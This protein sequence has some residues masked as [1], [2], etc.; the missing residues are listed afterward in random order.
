MKNKA[1]AAIPASRNCCGTVLTAFL[2]AC[3][4][5]AETLP[6]VVISRQFDPP[7]GPN[8]SR[9]EIHGGPSVVYQGKRYIY[10]W[11]PFPLAVDIDANGTADVMI[12][13]L[14]TEMTIAA[15][16]IGSTY[17]WGRAGG[18]M[19]LDFGSDAKAFSS[20]DVI[21]PELASPDPWVGWHNDD[22]TRAS[23]TL[24]GTISDVRFGEFINRGPVELLYLGVRFE[25]EGAAHYGWIAFNG[26]G[27]LGRYIYVHG[28]A[29]ESEPGV[30][31]IAGQ[32][33]EPVALLM[34]AGGSALLA[35][36]RRCLFHS[37]DMA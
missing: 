35:L 34:L 9:Y 3:A 2:T 30:G 18:V 17:M 28:W 16:A 31:L 26:S 25:R 8:I 20:G 10:D 13:K 12:I 4:L 27:A 23:A 32:V 33:P 37:P 21:G 5:M 6:A 22:S 11:V 24:A 15:S 19:G 36:R 1:A 29:Y 7:L 14:S